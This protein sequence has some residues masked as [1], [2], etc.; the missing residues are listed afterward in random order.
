[1]ELWKRSTNL[2]LALATPSGLSQG[3]RS[4]S[5]LK[6]TTRYQKGEL[7]TRLKIY[8]DPKSWRLSWADQVHPKK[9]NQKSYCRFDKNI[10]HNIQK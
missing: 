8:L 9:E 10:V 6:K 7:C 1:M 4:T 5:H 3:E 2:S